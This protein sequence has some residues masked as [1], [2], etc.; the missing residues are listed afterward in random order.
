MNVKSRLNAKYKIQFTLENKHETR[1][2]LYK[3]LVLTAA[4]VACCGWTSLTAQERVAPALNKDGDT[5]SNVNPKQPTWLERDNLT[6]DWGGARTWLKANGIILKPRLTQFYQGLTKGEGNLVFEYGAKA[7]LLLNAD[8]NKLGL[9]KG[10]SLTIHAEYNFGKSV[11]GQS[12]TLVP[13]NTALFFPGISG[14]NVFDVSSVYVIQ[15]FG[16]SVTLLLGKINMVDLFASKPF[17]GGAGID[18]FW[19]C[20]FAAPPSGTVPPYLF[21]ALLTLRT[22]TVKYG[23]WIYD[24]TSMIGKSGLEEPFSDG[25]TFRGSVDFPVTIGGLRGHQGFV[26]L[27]STQPGT[28]LKDLGDLILPPEPPGVA[29]IKNFRYY[30]NYTLDQ[31]LYQSKQNPNEGVGFFGQLGISDGNPNKLYWSTFVGVGGKGLIPGRSRDNWGAGYYYDVLSKYFIQA[32]EPIQHLNNNEQGWEFFYNFSLTPWLVIGA[33]FQLIKPLAST[34][35]ANYGGLRL[36]IN[37]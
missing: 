9:W 4:V 13:V 10:I 34:Q 36:M 5:I 35:N 31:Y 3:W 2:S 12:G 6:G 37:F 33:D 24:P 29:G 15:N 1:I 8:L 19:N 23:F 30:F 7:D 18:A 22:K 21:G 32:V 11:N 26:A 20:T 17:M 16:S 28:D 27:Y 25:V 14:P